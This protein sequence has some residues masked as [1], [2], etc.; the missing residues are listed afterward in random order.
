MIDGLE[1]LDHFLMDGQ[2]KVLAALRMDWEGAE[3]HFLL[4]LDCQSY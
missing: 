2:S 3:K 4:E 1:L